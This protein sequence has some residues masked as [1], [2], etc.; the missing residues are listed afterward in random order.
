MARV[1]EYRT[2]PDLVEVLVRSSSATLRW[3]ASKGVRFQPSYNRQAYKVDGKFTFWG[4]LALE[5]HG[6]GRASSTR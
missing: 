2:D 1:T 3:M 6:G 4:G 5:V